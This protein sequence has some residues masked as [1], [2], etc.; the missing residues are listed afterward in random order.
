MRRGRNKVYVMRALMLKIEHYAAKHFFIRLYAH[1]TVVYFIVLAEYAVKIAPAKEYCAAAA[2]A[3][4][5]RLLPA[6]QRGA[7]NMRL[8]ARAAVAGA[9]C[10]VY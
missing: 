10:A 1:H 5:Y 9:F 8:F 4:Y 2:F 7:G 3:A 6:V